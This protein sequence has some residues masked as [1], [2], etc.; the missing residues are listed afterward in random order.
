M[1][2]VIEKIRS[3]S[4]IRSWRHVLFC[5]TAMIFLPRGPARRKTCLLSTRRLPLA[6]DQVPARI[7][8]CS[9]LFNTGSRHCCE[10]GRP[11]RAI[12]CGGCFCAVDKRHGPGPFPTSKLPCP[13]AGLTLVP[14]EVC[15]ALL[16]LPSTES[17]QGVV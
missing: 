3:A 2:F 13:H 8:P 15:A 5:L 16:Y 12:A 4:F 11:R 10:E 14:L 7:L 1:G 17:Q 9:P 6:T